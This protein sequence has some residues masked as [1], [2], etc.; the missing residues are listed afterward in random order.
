MRDPT[1]PLVASCYPRTQN[2]KAAGARL[3]PK[4]EGASRITDDHRLL[5]C[6]LYIIRSDKCI[7]MRHVVDPVRANQTRLPALGLLPLEFCYDIARAHLLVA[8]FN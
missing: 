7:G 8:Y 6:A 1:A 4:Q 5:L 3:Y 2:P